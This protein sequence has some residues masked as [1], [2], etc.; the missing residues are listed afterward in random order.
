[1]SDNCK[2]SIVPRRVL[3]LF[4]FSFLFL[5]LNC[6][7]ARKIKIPEEMRTPD[8]VLA[9]LLEQEER[10][11]SVAAMLNFEIK[12]AGKLKGELELFYREPDEFVFHSHSFWGS[13]ILQGKLENDSILL[14]FPTKDEYYFDSYQNFSE[15]KFWKWEIEL[16]ALLNLAVG[17]SGIKKEARFT[18]KQ[19]SYFLFS[20]EDKEFWVNGENLNLDKAVWFIP[21]NS[22][23]LLVFYRKYKNWNDFSWPN[24][25]EVKLL[26]SNE[27]A[28]I[29]FEEMQINSSIP[30]KKWEI[31][32]P[33]D[34]NRVEIE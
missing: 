20:Q 23:T 18:E 16:K 27:S 24:A 11:K 1:V 33:S 15:T 17:K 5:L 8:K 6:F 2:W 13:S 34:A 22:D 21:E 32:I 3:A 25:I 29:K 7:P 12:G 4:I 28:K 10:I 26:S 19:K 14:Y 31:Q 30:D 9:Q